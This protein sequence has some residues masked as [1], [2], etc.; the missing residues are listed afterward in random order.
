M[1]HQ[2]DVNVYRRASVEHEYRVFNEMT[3]LEFELVEATL[4]AA[5]KMNADHKESPK[6]P[7]PFSRLERD[8]IRV[9]PYSGPDVLQ[10]FLFPHRKEVPRFFFFNAGG[11]EDE[12]IEAEAEAS[13]PIDEA[14]YDEK[15]T[16]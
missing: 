9:L 7:Q 11:D 8:H 4:R 16:I 1:N 6:P 13:D 5:E 10:N 12:S 14:T 15:D 2:S 3:T